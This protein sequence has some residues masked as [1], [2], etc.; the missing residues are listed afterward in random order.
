MQVEWT[1]KALRDYKSVKSNKRIINKIHQLL[2]SIEDKYDYGIGK[3]ERLKWY[4]E[5]LLYSRRI[6]EKNRIVYEVFLDSNE[7]YCVRIVILQIIGH[8]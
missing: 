3:P 4:Q 5:R 8:Y 2:E 1:K 7:V 6:D